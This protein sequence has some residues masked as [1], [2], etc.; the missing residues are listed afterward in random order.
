MSGLHGGIVYFKFKSAKKY[1][2]VTFDAPHIRLFD[3]KVKIV[4][5]KSLAGGM[6]FQLAVTNAQTK[7]RGLCRTRDACVLFYFFLSRSMCCA[8]C[9]PCP[10]FT[11]AAAAAA[12]ATARRARL[13]ALLCFGTMLR[14]CLFQTNT[15]P[16][17]AVAPPPGNGVQLGEIMGLWIYLIEEEDRHPFYCILGGVVQQ[18]RRKWQQFFLSKKKLVKTKTNNFCRT[19]TWLRGGLLRRRRRACLFF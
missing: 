4:E 5:M 18:N 19:S 10:H 7:V 9:S 13:R 8:A 2:M 14:A 16:A 1:D 15:R 11:A 12:A 6:D 3:L 17:N